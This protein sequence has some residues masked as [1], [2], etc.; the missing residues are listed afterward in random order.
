MDGND[1]CRPVQYHK[2]MTATA[3]ADWF[4]LLFSFL[5]FWNIFLI[6]YSSIPAFYHFFLSSSFFFLASY[7]DRYSPFLP[8]TVVVVDY[9]FYIDFLFILSFIHHLL[10]QK[11]SKV[12]K[13]WWPSANQRQ[14]EEEEEEDEEEEEEEEEEEAPS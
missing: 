6:L 5:F 3:V 10:R 11:E 7:F 12:A 4:V 9:S 2:S 13:L 1:E 14:E 8:L